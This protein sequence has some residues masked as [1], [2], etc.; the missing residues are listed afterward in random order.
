MALP[1]E[2]TPVLNDKEAAAFIKR[3]QRDENRR[4]NYVPTPKLKEAIAL[5]RINAAKKQS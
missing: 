3:V 4:A 1:I 5:I 2:P